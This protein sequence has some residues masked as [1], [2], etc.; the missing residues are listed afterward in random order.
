MVVMDWAAK[1]FG[2]DAVFHGQSGIGGGIILVSLQS[3]RTV[4]AHLILEVLQGSASEACLTVAV[5]ARERCLRILVEKQVTEKAPI[6]N[7][8]VKE[9]SLASAGGAGI[10]TGVDGGRVKARQVV[11]PEALR[12]AST[13]KMVMYGST[14]THSIGKKVSAFLHKSGTGSNFIAWMTGGD[15]LGNGV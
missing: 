7:G 4:V 5:A 1:L 13:P 8:H 12:A 9:D 10:T 6:V 11:I 3:R 2:L 14:Q 15:H